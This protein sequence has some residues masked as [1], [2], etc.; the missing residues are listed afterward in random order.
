MLGDVNSDPIVIGK[1][2]ALQLEA[3]MSERFIALGVPQQLNS[4]WLTLRTTDCLGRPGAGVQVRIVNTSAVSWQE[5]DCVT[6]YGRS[7]VHV[8]PNVITMAELRHDYRS[9]H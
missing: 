7:A 5:N 9:G 6:T 8:R 2:I 1:P 3:T 4:G